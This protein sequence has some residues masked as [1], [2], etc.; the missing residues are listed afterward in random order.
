MFGY[1]TVNKLELK[2]RE[3][4]RYRG[5][6]CG[7]CHILRKKYGKIGQITL[8]YD[9]TFLIILLSALYEEETIEE[10]QRCLIHPAKKHYAIWN[11]ITEYAADMNIALTYH[12]LKDDWDDERSYA[13][14]AG[15]KI[16]QRKYK[17]IQEKYPKQCHAIEA[18]L[19]NLAQCEARGEE[20]I[21][22][23]AKCFGELMEAIFVYKEDNWK[24]YLQ[25]I[26]FF[27]GKYI[28]L[29]DAYDDIEKDRKNHNYNPF[30]NWENE[31]FHEQ[32]QEVLTMMMAE[33]TREFEKLPI[34]QELGILKNILYLGVWNKFDEIQHKITKERQESIT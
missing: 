28:Y 26:G 2:V 25:K 17:K 32:C 30:L 4:N 3:Y 19:E 24:P 15:S 8:T 31:D 13:G 10:M 21:D 12:H 18:A 29:L 6:Y 23:V 7:L 5:Y 27:L 16:L 33:C 14:L 9:M 22:I 11:K 34:E 20:N 1:V